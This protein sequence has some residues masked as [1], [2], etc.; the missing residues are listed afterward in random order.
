[1]NILK[2]IGKSFAGL[3]VLLGIT[4][5]IM[6]YFG[7]YAVNNFHVLEKD[8]NDYTLKSMS[9]KGELDIEQFRE[10]CRQ[11]SSDENCKLLEQNPITEQLKKE[12]IEFRYYGSAMRIIGFIFFIFGFLL[13]V[14]CSSWMDGLRQASLISL[15]GSLFSYFYYK[16][17]IM[18]ALNSFLPPE[19]LG[20]VNN[21][22]AASINQTTRFITI[23]IVIFLILTI[24]LYVLKH[25]KK[26]EGKT[27]GS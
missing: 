6:S 9:E 3:L 24:V 27:N 1:M 5:F 7:A 19:V 23:L 21:W 17:M 15:I 13:F 25:K 20:V 4:I 8:I 26:A 18:G 22:A 11:N 2:T 12:I 16:Y 14:L 10:Y